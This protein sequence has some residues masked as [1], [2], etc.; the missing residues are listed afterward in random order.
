M[1]AIISVS[2]SAGAT[3]FERT[4]SAAYS[5]A[6]DFANVISAAFEAEYAAEAV[7]VAGRAHPGQHAARADVRARQVD[8]D[9]PAPGVRSRPLE[10]LGD[11]DARVRDEQLDGAELPLDRRDRLVDLR[12][13][14][15]V[16]R[17]TE[18]A[19]EGGRLEVADRGARAELAKGL[20]DA[21]ADAA[22]APGHERDPSFDAV[23]LH[24]TRLSPSGRS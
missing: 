6:I 20:G 15:H 1:P 8:V 11:Q 22:R 23:E 9:Q 10:R 3:A 5:F 7:P 16:G 13:V 24:A 17:E 19:V 14:R 2:I 12:L 18:D 4:P 21:V